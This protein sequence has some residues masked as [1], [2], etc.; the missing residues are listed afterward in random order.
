MKRKE[1]K[2]SSRQI[3]LDIGSMRKHAMKL[4]ETEHEYN[5]LLSTLLRTD[6]YY[7]DNAPLPSLKELSIDSGVKYGK[8]NRQLRMIYEELIFTKEKDEG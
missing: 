8:V 3:I 5:A 2:L 4:L 7:D 1:I 6:F